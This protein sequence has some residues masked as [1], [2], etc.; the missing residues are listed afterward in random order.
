[1]QKTCNCVCINMTILKIGHAEAYMC[2]LWF[3]YEKI[4]INLNMQKEQNDL[5]TWGTLILSNKLHN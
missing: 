4:E 1:M 2:L 5:F 3:K